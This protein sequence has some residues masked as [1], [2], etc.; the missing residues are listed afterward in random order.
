MRRTEEWSCVMCHEVV[1]CHV[2]MS[3]VSQEPGI[4][5]EVSILIMIIIMIMIVIMIMRPRAG[6]SQSELV[7]AYP[8]IYCEQR[9]E[10]CGDMVRSIQDY[11]HSSVLVGS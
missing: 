7:A 2:T 6:N 5:H 8:W 9:R 4:R 10:E 3:R 11:L 1:M